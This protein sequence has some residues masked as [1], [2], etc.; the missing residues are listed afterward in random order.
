MPEF[1]WSLKECEIQN[2]PIFWAAQRMDANE[3]IIQRCQ[4]NNWCNPQ[5]T[6][7]PRTVVSGWNQ[8]I[9]GLL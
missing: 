1:V 2:Q 3:D 7:V 9:V 8:I 4:K 6:K 5:E